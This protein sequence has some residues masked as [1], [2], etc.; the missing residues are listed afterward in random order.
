ME[1]S[2]RFSDNSSSVEWYNAK[3]NSPIDRR[4]VPVTK[5]LIDPS[6]DIINPDAGPNTSN[7]KANGSI[8]FVAIIASAPKP[9]GDGF[10]M[11]T[12]IV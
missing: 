12:G 6:F 7:T 10:S 4:T 3:L 8:T 9:T 1:R 5:G 11:N 2:A